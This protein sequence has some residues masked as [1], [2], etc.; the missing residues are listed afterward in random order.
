LIK[1]LPFGIRKGNV[2]RVVLSRP[3]VRATAGIFLNVFVVSHNYLNKKA[4]RSGP[5]WGVFF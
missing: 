1:S 3:K 2:V 5:V 4:R